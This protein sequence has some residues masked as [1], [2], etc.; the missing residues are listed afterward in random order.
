MQLRSKICLG[1]MILL[2]VTA[3][4]V[5]RVPLSPLSRHVR[6]FSIGKTTALDS[7]IW[8]G[9]SEHIC[10]G[11]EFYGS[12]L[13]RI[14]QINMDDATV[15]EIVKNILGSADAYQLSV[16]DNVILIRRERAALPDW[17]NYRLP[18][19]KVPRGEL[20]AVNNEL[21]MAL[22]M[23]LDPSKR[24]FVGDYPQTDPIEEVGPFNEHGKTVRE[25]LIKIVA[26]SSGATWYPTQNVQSLAPASENGFWTLVTYS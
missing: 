15:G 5:K 9:R 23:T 17:L 4:T 16:F 11:I 1:A 8:L 18:Q 21:W 7:L 22:E 13:S 25:L 19:F 14:V 6:H 26:A 10:F 12:D 24:G 3:P 2:P 20:M